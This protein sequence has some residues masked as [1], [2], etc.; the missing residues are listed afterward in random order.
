MDAVHRDTG[1]QSLLSLSCTTG[2][3]GVLIIE[4]NHGFICTVTDLTPSH[5]RVTASTYLRH[6]QAQKPTPN[7]VNPVIIVSVHLIR[8][9]F[10]LPTSSP[11]LVTSALRLRRYPYYVQRKK[12]GVSRGLELR[13][14]QPPSL[15]PC[16][17]SIRHPSPCCCTQRVK[18]GFN[19]A[20]LIGSVS[21]LRSAS[22]RAGGWR[23]GEQA[24][25]FGM[26]AI[27]SCELAYG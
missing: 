23:G 2:V 25:C 7:L 26:Q 27:S 9:F 3:R 18:G 15:G 22:R 20:V 4:A 13:Q 12:G 8:G 10:L 21:R 1:F 17:F 16:I 14:T 11:F 5:A 24:Y 6:T 19:M